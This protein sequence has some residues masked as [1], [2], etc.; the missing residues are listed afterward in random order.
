[1]QLLSNA[2]IFIMYVVQGLPFGMQTDISP[3][4][5]KRW[6][7]SYKS[8]GFVNL[9]FWPW[10]LKPLLAPYMEHA[11]MPALRLSLWALAALHCGVCA[12][13]YC[14]S[15]P[16]LALALLLTNACAA[17]Y[18]ILVDKQAIR[19]RSSEANSGGLD[20]TNSLQVVGYKLGGLMS[21]SLVMSAA[22]LSSPSPSDPAAGL[23]LLLSPALSA[24]CTAGLAVALSTGRFDESVSKN[25]E[26]REGLST[27][28]AVPTDT[29]SL[30]A[31]H[32]K[33]NASLY[34]LVLTYKL[35]E[36]I[37]DKLL[38]LFLQDRGMD[39]SGLAALNS[40]TDVVGILG[41]CA[42]S[43]L[44]R[45]RTDLNKLLFVLVLNIIPQMLRYLIVTNE[46][47]Q[48]MS[49]LVVISSIEYF[50][51][52]AVTVS[53]FNVMFSSVLPGREGAHYSLLAALEVG[54]KLAAG[55]L[56]IFLVADLGF[57]NLFLIAALSS[58][59]PVVVLCAHIA[60]SDATETKTVRDSAPAVLAK[61]DNNT[62]NTIN[63]NNTI[64]TINT[65]N[66]KE[67]VE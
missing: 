15:A 10:V 14:R 66:N 38:K 65:N 57:E 62:V 16:L 50:I 34:A 8:M 35:G 25:I 24:L 64:N 46:Q 39:L 55:S 61:N 56:A 37:G 30:L 26:S 45:Q 18:D 31:N 47:F 9:T 32:L 58:V 20:L 53:L 19:I 23:L 54:G 4:L 6:G 60:S 36:T 67:H 44:P 17:L 13:A 33:A 22:A 59:V 21:G 40:W 2:H 41:S 12:A 1:M 7:Y 51:G 49:A 28:A 11:E 29:F 3:F 5:L 63:T 52:G 48:S 42:T 43:L 27:A